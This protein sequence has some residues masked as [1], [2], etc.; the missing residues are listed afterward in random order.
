MDEP[1]GGGL[2]CA[3]A[4]QIGQKFTE[5]FN[6][7]HFKFIT[8]PGRDA[9]EAQKLSIMTKRRRFCDLVEKNETGLLQPDCNKR[10][11]HVS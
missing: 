2:T 9:S 8:R 11:L 3:G 7:F 5:S 6:D 4:L 10:P 1:Y